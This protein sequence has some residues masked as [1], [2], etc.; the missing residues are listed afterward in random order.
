MSERKIKVVEDLSDLLCEDKECWLDGCQ[1]CPEE[2]K[3]CEV[4]TPASV[5]PQ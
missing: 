1:N 5:I 3:D 2:I 4:D